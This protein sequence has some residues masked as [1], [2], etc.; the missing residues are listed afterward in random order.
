LALFGPGG[1]ACSG[2]SCC[3]V[4]PNWFRSFEDGEQVF[5]ISPTAVDINDTRALHVAT[6]NWA[7]K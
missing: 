1:C 7:A 2:W 4:I 3:H 6:S 5:K